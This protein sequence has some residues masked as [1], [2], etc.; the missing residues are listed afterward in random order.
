M[1]EREAERCEQKLLALLFLCKKKMYIPHALIRHAHAPS[2]RLI[3]ATSVSAT[4]SATK[5]TR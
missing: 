3:E 2:L 1:R 4:Q 5:V